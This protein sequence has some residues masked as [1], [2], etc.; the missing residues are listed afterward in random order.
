MGASRFIADKLRFKG[1]LAMAAIAVSF[2]VMII[3]VAVSSGFRKAVRDGVSAVGGDIQITPLDQNFAGETEPLPAVLSCDGRIRALPG[4]EDIVPVVYRAGIVKSGEL[5]HGVLVKGVPERTDSALCVSIPSRLSE[6][7]GL[8]AGDDLVTYFIGETVKVRKF[9]ITNVHPSLLDV[10]ETLIVEARLPDMQRLNGWGEDQASA[11]E[12]ILAPAARDRAEETASEI[13][14]FLLQSGDEREQDLYAA[15]APRRYPQLFD[16]LDLLD[17]NVVFV[18]ILMTLV[19]GFNMISGL[20]IL[21]FR[22]IPTIGTL[23]TLGMTDR[24]IGHVFLRVSAVLV[25]KGMLI[26]NAAALL[27]CLIQGTTHLIRLNPVNYFVSYVPV[28]VN[29]PA[30]LC[31]DAAAFAVILLLLWIPTLFIARVDPADTVRMK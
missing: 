18:L 9:H 3:A 30:I 31:A 15:S 5:I 13:G 25:F 6:I 26:G 21:L 4:V 19:A 28:S 22:N 1:G 12:V 10:G 16:W 11:L 20:L 23:K 17:F 24:A 27:F 29:L 2:L 7:T 8:G 14:M